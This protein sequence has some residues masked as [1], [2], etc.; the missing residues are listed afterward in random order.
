MAKALS[1]SKTVSKKPAGK[2]I[3][4]APK[5][6]KPPQSKGKAAAPVK[7]TPKSTPAA[8]PKTASKLSAPD[9]KAPPPASSRKAV[10]KAPI[11]EALSKSQRT[12]AISPRVPLVPPVVSKTAIAKKATQSSKP[13]AVEKNPP[14]VTKTPSVRATA[15]SKLATTTPDEPVV[16]SAMPSPAAARDKKADKTE[17][18][19]ATGYR[20]SDKE[21]FMGPEHQEYFRQKLLHWRDDLIEESKQTIDNLREEVRDVGDEAERATRETENSLELRTRDRYRKL[22]SKINKALL[23]IEDGSYGYCEE[24]GEPI[25]VARLD[26]RPIATLSLDAQERW[27][28]RQKQMGD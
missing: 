5:V 6:S 21:E 1:K 28:H 9:H 11:E 8:K 16:A 13:S 14:V 12:A 19:L 22:L 18:T 7:A 10:A 24:T 25:G 17:V 3:A 2:A 4:V 26:A 23:R 15:K 27:E 20:P